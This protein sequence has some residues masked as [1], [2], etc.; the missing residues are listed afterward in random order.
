MARDKHVTRHT[1]GLEIKLETRVAPGCTDAPRCT[2]GNP[3]TSVTG[4]QRKGAG[5]Q[6]GAGLELPGGKNLSLFTGERG[7]RTEV[8]LRPQNGGAF[9]W[10]PINR[11]FYHPE[12]CVLAIFMRKGSL[13]VS[14]F[15]TSRR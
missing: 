15:V 7:G 4:A 11:S 3:H 14:L 6:G 5:G 13:G 9:L 1:C 10:P 2:R 8:L 12:A